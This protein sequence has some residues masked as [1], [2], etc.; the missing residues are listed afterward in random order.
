MASPDAA[1]A[2]VCDDR[3]VRQSVVIVDDHDAFRSSAT[4]LLEAAGFD[5]IGEASDGASALSAVERLHPDVVLLDVRLPDLD[6]FVVAAQLAAGATPPA[7]VLISSRD[8]VVYGDRV[9]S[10]PARGFIAKRELS[11]SSLA[12]LL[13]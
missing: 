6:G 11:G 4:A 3:G 8:A 7:V 13:E 1:R 9:E 10:A 12:R 2:P 5:V